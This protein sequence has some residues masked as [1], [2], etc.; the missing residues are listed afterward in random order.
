MEMDLH[1][2]ARHERER[3]AVGALERHV[4]HGRREHVAFGELEREM[5]DHGAYGLSVGPKPAGRGGQPV[6]LAGLARSDSFPEPI[7]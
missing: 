4:A 5:F 2:L 6:I 7:R 3:L 1:E